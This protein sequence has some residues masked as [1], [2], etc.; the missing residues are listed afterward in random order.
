M[1][2]DIPPDAPLH[3]SLSLRIPQPHIYAQLLDH[4]RSHPHPLA[5]LALRALAWA[6]VAPRPLAL[7]ELACGLAVDPAHPAVLSNAWADVSQILRL[8]TRLLEQ[9][10]GAVHLAHE[11][12]R[13]FLPAYLAR[14]SSGSDGGAGEPAID[15]HEDLASACLTYLTMPPFRTPCVSPTE[16]HNRLRTYPFLSYASQHWFRHAQRVRGRFCG[17]FEGLIRLAL[18]PGSDGSNFPTSWMQAARPLIEELGVTHIAQLPAD[19]NRWM[20]NLLAKE[21]SMRVLNYFLAGGMTREMREGV[22]GWSPLRVAARYGRV[23]VVEELVG[24][25]AYRVEGEREEA[26]GLACQSGSVEML[27]LLLAAGDL[28]GGSE[29]APGVVT[30]EGWDRE[31]T[32][33]LVAAGGRIYPVVQ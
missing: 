27:R 9:R 29:T 16:L 19:D 11:S 5:P 2:T 6:A 4:L 8:A 1:A 15:P 14:H 12:L 3:I 26:L 25:G 20:L 31:I 7:N 23:E 24:A 32:R 17:P 22:G 30:V 33:E 28:N 21:G 18:V 10:H 13:D